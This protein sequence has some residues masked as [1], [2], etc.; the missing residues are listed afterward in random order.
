MWR[1]RATPLPT[2]LEHPIYP[3]SLLSSVHVVVFHL[4]VDMD[5]VAIVYYSLHTALCADK[6][7]TQ[8]LS[9]KYSLCSSK[10]KYNI[11]ENERG[12]FIYTFMKTLEAPRNKFES[13]TIR[14]TSAQDPRHSAYYSWW[15][16]PWHRRCIPSHNDTHRHTQLPHSRTRQ[17]RNVRYVPRVYYQRGPAP[18]RR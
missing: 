9:L 2:S 15:W 16:T 1:A 11:I 12:H 4:L 13:S 5:A 3:L 14:R 7:A 6:N 10:A 8:L 17:R 18:G